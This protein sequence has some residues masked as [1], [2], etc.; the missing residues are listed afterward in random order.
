MQT[1]IIYPNNYG[2]LSELALAL[3]LKI[4]TCGEY[5][6]ITEA[7]TVSERVL[8]NST[9]EKLRSTT[10]AN[11]CFL[12]LKAK[13]EEKALKLAKTLPHIWEC[14]EIL[15]LEMLSSDASAIELKKGIH[16]PFCNL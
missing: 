7:I 4:N 10:R 11:L 3:T 14:R 13:E 1:T 9:N 16:N 12:Y 5:E 15:L 6:L 2:F 8:L